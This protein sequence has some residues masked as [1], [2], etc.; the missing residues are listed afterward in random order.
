MLEDIQKKL[1][2]VITGLSDVLDLEIANMKETDLEKHWYFQYDKN[3][4]AH[5]NL[6]NFH[7]MLELYGLT[8][9]EWEEKHNGIVCL[10]ERVRDKYLM[11]K[12]HEFIAMSSSK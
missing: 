9:R 4:E 6:Y 1:T 2:N 12:I 5:I 8:C 7:E 3:A 10:E 11:P